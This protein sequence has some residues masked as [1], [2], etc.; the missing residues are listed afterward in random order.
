MFLPFEITSVDGLHLDGVAHPAAARGGGTVVL[1]HGITADMDEGGMSVRLADELAG[2]GLTVIRFSFRG[3]G[4]SAGTEE[5]VTVAG[6]M[7]A[8]RRQL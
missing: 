8:Q 6:E 4:R 5:G 3:H 7:P 1:A 2:R